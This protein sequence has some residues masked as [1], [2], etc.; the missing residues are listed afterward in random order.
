[1]PSGRPA[2][3]RRWTD[4]TESYVPGGGGTPNMITGIGNVLLLEPDGEL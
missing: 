4:E 2:G 3:S 1:M